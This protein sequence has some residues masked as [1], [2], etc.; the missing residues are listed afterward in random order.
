MVFIATNF[1]KKYNLSEA[2]SFNGSFLMWTPD[3]LNFD[4]QIMIDDV[5]QTQSLFF[6]SMQLVDSVQTPYAREKGYI[7]YRSNPQIDVQ[8]KWREIVAERK[9]EFNF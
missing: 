9:R 4:R 5:L 3:S 6:A 1:F 8:R 2:C 7:Y